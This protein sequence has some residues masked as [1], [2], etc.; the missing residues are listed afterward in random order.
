M[1]LSPKKE[2]MQAIE[3]SPDEV[4]QVLLELLRVLQ[5]HDR[6]LSEPNAKMLQSAH[7]ESE[8][9][10]NKVPNRLYRKQGILVIETEYSDGFDIN[11]LIDEVREG[12]IQDQIRQVHS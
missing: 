1:A 11:S 7:Q 10:T 4:A 8:D 2:L 3:Q 9:T 5:Q 6:L 12:R